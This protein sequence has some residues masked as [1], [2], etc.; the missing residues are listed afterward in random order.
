M[1]PEVQDPLSAHVEECRHRLAAGLSATADGA[2]LAAYFK[3]GKMIRARLVFASAAAVGGDPARVTYAA[4]AI[5]LLHGA[6]LFHD[7]LIDGTDE[8]RGLPA[9]HRRM[10]LSEALLLGDFL[11][12]RAFDILCQAQAV[13]CSAHQAL[14]AIQ[15][16]AAH[17]QACCRG[18]R[19]EVKLSGQSI[20][21]S[22]Y[23]SI[24]EDKTAAPFM[25]ATA[26][27]AIMGNGTK[28]DREVFATY[29]RHFG[30]VFQ[31][32]DDMLDLLGDREALGKPVGN[33][34]ACRRPLLPVIYL[35]KYGSPAARAEWDELWQR[36]PTCRELLPILYREGIIERVKAT[37]ESHVAAAVSSLE[38]MPDGDGLRTL[39]E[40]PASVLASWS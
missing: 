22:T 12:L 38:G 16:L 31:I 20:S 3:R 17:A 2:P 1:I 37:Q 9:L 24:V 34:L 25:A 5:E 35:W 33:S 26:L 32:C 15:V 27:G 19:L 13:A 39:L 21:E 10:S 11:L 40:L 7:D 6:S 4:E 14:S 18:E 28:R 36:D 23:F 29:A 30:V 8:R